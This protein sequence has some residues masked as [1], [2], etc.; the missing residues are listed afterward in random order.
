MIGV[1]EHAIDRYIERW[2]PSLMTAA[3]AATPAEFDGLLRAL[4]QHEPHREIVDDRL[5]RARARD[6]ILAL[7]ASS[8]HGRFEPYVGR[9]QEVRYAELGGRVVPLVRVDGDI[10]TVLPDP[11]RS[12]L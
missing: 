5:A 11:G 12:V 3:R 1:F 8:Q 6:E 2:R 10:R 4:R 9:I 7:W